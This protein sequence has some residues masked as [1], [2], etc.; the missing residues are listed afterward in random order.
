[1]VAFG[2]GEVMGG[3][4]HGLTIDAIGSRKT[5][6]VNLLI[7]TTLTGVT[8]LSINLLTYNYV[9]FIMCFMWGY[10]D[11][12]QNTFLFQILGFEFA[13][14][15]DPFGVFTVWQG[16]SVF[17]FQMIEGNFVDE[18]NQHQLTV[19]TIIIGVIGLIFNG[20]TFGFKFRVDQARMKERAK[21]RALLIE[22]YVEGSQK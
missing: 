1:M 3:I 11:G 17:S 21:K 20:V 10:Q 22:S 15:S 2:V 18:N 5:I 13:S 16:L 9:T 6:F 8:I 7:L 4:N 12:S 14:N 19:Y